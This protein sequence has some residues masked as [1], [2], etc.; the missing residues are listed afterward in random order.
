MARDDLE[1]NRGDIFDFAKSNGF[2]VTAAIDAGRRGRHWRSRRNKR[3]CDRRALLPADGF[4]ACRLRGDGLLKRVGIY[5][6]R[7]AW[8]FRL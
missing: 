2:E 7:R 3:I 1:N 6:K 8:R 5:F 4:G